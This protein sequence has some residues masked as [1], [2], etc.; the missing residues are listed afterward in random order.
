MADIKISLLDFAGALSGAEF[1]PIVQPVTDPKG[2]KK[3]SITTLMG[4]APVQSVNGHTGIVA[5]TSADVGAVAVGSNISQLTNDAGYALSSQLAPFADNVAIIKN[6][7]DTTKRI[8]LSAAS[9]TTATTRTLTAQNADYTIAGTS[10]ILGGTGQT[11]VTIGDILHGTGANTWGKLAAVATG[12]VLLSGGVATISAW[13]KVGLTTHISG[14]LP[15]ANGGIGVTSVNANLVF[16]GPSS[17]AAAA[18]AFRALV[19]DDLPNVVIEDVAGT[20]YTFLETDRNKIKRFTNVAGCTATLPNSLSLGWNTTAYRG[21]GAG[22]LTLTATTALESAGTTLDVAATAVSLFHRGSNIFVGVGAVGAGSAS[23]SDGDKGDIT[24][25]DGGETWLIN[26]NINKAWTGSHSFIDSNFSLL[27]NS[28]NTKIAKFEVSGITTATTR[29]YSTPNF[30]GGMLVSGGVNVL[31]GDTVIS[32]GGSLRNFGIGEVGT[33]VGN[34]QVTAG[35]TAVITASATSVLTLNATSAILQRGTRGI[36]FNNTQVLLA[37]TS[38]AT[39]DMYYNGGST[40]VTR[41]VAVATGNA[42]ISGGVATAPAWGKIGLSTHV[43]GN[44]S[45]SN[46]DGGSGASATTFW[47]GDGVWATPSGGGGG[48]ITNSAANNELMKSNGTNAVSSGL[49]SSSSGNLALGGGITAPDRTFH[50]E[51]DDAFN[52]TVTFLQRLTHTT[53]GAPAPAA[54]MGVGFEFELETSAA[55][56][57]ITSIIKSVLVSGSAANEYADIV[58]STMGEGVIGDVLTVSKLAGPTS[59]LVA[60]G[61]TLDISSTGWKFNSPVIINS[62]MKV[63]IPP[64]GDAT[65]DRRLHVEQVGAGSAM[66][67][68]TRMTAVNSTTPAAGAGVGVEYEVMTAAGNNEIG[69]IMELVTTDVTAASEDFDFVIKLMAGG[70]T[71]SEVIRFTSVGLVNIGN[72]SPPSGIGATLFVQNKVANNSSA[73]SISAD[74]NTASNATAIL[75]LSRTRGT[76]VGANVAVVADDYLGAINF[77]GGDGTNRVYA[78]MVAVHVDGTVGTNDMPARLSFWTTADGASSPTERMRI[79]NKGNVGLFGATTFDTGVGV[80]AMLNAGTAPAAGDADMFL[81]YSK[82]ISAGVAAPHFMTE[83]GIEIR[84]YQVATYTIT[85]GT[86][87]RTLDANSTTLDELADFATT[88]AN[89][90]KQTRI[91]G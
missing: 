13:G 20:T 31:S 79:N 42:L 83:N 49:Y 14:T 59:R 67:Y 89:D 24:A 10:A 4:L 40:V 3:V 32:G 52:N 47:R 66:V 71:A 60:Q 73:I 84:L 1:I 54:G 15:V 69:G 75:N 17:G 81:M 65:I 70:A 48:G 28:D 56:N 85:N 37:L 46:L 34:F 21:S 29:T 88:L 41:L 30:S 44:L 50:I 87:V 78:G 55:N 33:E 77:Y 63:G 61:Q 22:V 58:L 9:V 38:D 53:S 74:A 39:G 76:T 43:S 51:I 25:S 12:N 7:G 11:T 72:P 8:I 68:T 5:L 26:I 18:P 2:N 86:T 6:S 19:T 57:E 91:L 90:L 27:D 23:V 80:M 62:D 82:D 16:A 45:P 36:T 64:A 35:T